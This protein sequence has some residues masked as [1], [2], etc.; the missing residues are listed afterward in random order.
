MREPIANRQTIDAGNI[1]ATIHPACHVY[2]MV[3]EDAI[4]DDDILGRQPRCRLDRPHLRRSA[5]R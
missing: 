2:K 1:R 4:Y 3:P 5:P